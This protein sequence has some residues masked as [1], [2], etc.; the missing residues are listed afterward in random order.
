M[1]NICGSISILVIMLILVLGISCNNSLPRTLKPSQ[2]TVTSTT[3]KQINT[4]TYTTKNYGIPT[5]T[6]PTMKTFTSEYYGVAVNLPVSWRAE[7]ESYQNI[8]YQIF[9]SD[10]ALIVQMEISTLDQEFQ[11][12]HKI[13]T[14]EDAVNW[15]LKLGNTVDRTLLSKP[16]STTI[17]GF[18]ACVVTYVK[19]SNGSWH[20][21]FSIKKGNLLYTV[22]GMTQDRI[23][24]PEIEA[25]LNSFRFIN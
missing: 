15:Y 20:E 18:P 14:P 3:T 7:Q 11:R 24:K 4:P 13:Y 9:L 8:P 12:L 2:K 16:T 19:P 5:S 17:Q 22:K 1:R 6:L 21:Y 10:P 25:M 23:Y